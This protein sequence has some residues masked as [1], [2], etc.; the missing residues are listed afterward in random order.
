MEVFVEHAGPVVQRYVEQVLW[1][2]SR[3]WWPPGG[4]RIVFIPRH[5]GTPHGRN[6]GRD[7]ELSP[8]TAKARP[9]QVLSLLFSQ[10]GMCGIRGKCPSGLANG[11]VAGGE[12]GWCGEGTY[13]RILSCPTTNNLVP[14]CPLQVGNETSRPAS[15]AEPSTCKSRVWPMT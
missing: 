6:K 5:A 3:L 11:L 14:T 9:S 4:K 12:W 13:G 2:F 15:D 7:E 1:V 10:W 8:G